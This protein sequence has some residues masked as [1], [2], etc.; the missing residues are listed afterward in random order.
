MIESIKLSTTPK[1][2]L[3]NLKL[4]HKYSGFHTLERKKIAYKLENN[5]VKV[6]TNAVLKSSAVHLTSTRPKTALNINL[7]KRQVCYGNLFR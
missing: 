4:P 6:N 1:P 3:T 5:L 7:K 2:K